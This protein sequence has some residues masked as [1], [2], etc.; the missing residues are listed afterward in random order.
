MKDN[1]PLETL[2]NIRNSKAFAALSPAI[3]RIAEMDID[4]WSLDDDSPEISAT[5]H[6]ALEIAMVGSNMSTQHNDERLVGAC[7]LAARHKGE[8][9][10]YHHLLA[11]Q[12]FKS[13]YSITDYEVLYP[14]TTE[15]AEDAA[16][17]EDA[18]TESEPEEDDNVPD[19][20]QQEQVPTDDNTTP[21]S[22]EEFP[23]RK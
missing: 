8:I 4:I 19:E 21:S 11:R 5:R 18:A 9:P 15:E 20:T 3:N 12:D 17:E 23:K 6:A 22:A 1:L 13:E 16:G 10:V 7:P 2:T 14:I